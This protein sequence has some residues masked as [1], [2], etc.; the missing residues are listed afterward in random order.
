MG[1]RG[2]IH[3]LDLMQKEGQQLNGVNYAHGVLCHLHP[4]GFW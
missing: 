2:V 4:I 3:T 1:G